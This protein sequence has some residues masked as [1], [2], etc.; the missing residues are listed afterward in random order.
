MTSPRLGTKSRLERALPL[1]GLAMP[2]G[3]AEQ[4][5]RLRIN[6]NCDCGALSAAAF[7]VDLGN[8]QARVNALP[9]AG[10][11]EIQRYESFPCAQRVSLSETVARAAS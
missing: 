3:E 9:R 8:S 10:A 4:K 5:R 7:G 6:E 2:R 1:C 11:C